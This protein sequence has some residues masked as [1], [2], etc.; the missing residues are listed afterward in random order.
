MNAYEWLENAAVAFY[1]D[2]RK[3]QAAF[4]ESGRRAK[5]VSKPLHGLK[6]IAVFENGEPTL[7]VVGPVIFEVFGGV[8]LPKAFLVDA[9][10]LRKAA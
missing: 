6:R 10:E 7:M 4:P 3:W 2:I 5:R 1:D 9:Q 8:V